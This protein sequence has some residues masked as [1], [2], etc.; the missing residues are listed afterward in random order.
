MPIRAAFLEPSGAPCVYLAGQ[1]ARCEEFLVQEV[2][3]ELF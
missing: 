3:E 1:E 2:D